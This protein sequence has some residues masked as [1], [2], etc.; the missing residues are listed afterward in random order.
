MSMRKALLKNLFGSLL[1]IYITTVPFYG[2]PLLVCL[3]PIILLDVFAAN[4][5]SWK[6][7]N[8][9]WQERIGDVISI[10]S[11]FLLGYARA[12]MDLQ[13]ACTLPLWLQYVLG[14]LVVDAFGYWI[15]Y[16]AH[17]S[18]L[19]W[20]LHRVHHSRTSPNVWN[21]SYEHFGDAMFRLI[22]PGLL[23]V[24][25]GFDHQ[26]IVAV[27]SLTALVGT[28]S[29]LNLDV[30]IPQPFVWLIVNPITHRIHHHKNEVA[31]NNGNITHLWDC[32]MGTY[33]LYEMQPD[34]YGLKP[35]QQISDAPTH[36]FFTTLK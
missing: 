13:S 9:T 26:I 21:A 23:L 34:D 31:V 24:L 10:L 6:I 32:I 19:L 36:I 14:V 28:V 15:H 4:S 33:A 11:V 17:G 12:N 29:H 20:K 5:F 7:H 3:A 2:L 1:I 30:S 27:S 22:A 16:F 35:E 8:W 18:N 25:F